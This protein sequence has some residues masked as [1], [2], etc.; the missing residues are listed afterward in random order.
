[1]TTESAVG[2]SLGQPYASAPSTRSLYRTAGW[3]AVLGGGSYAVQ[4]VLVFLVPSG[5]DMDSAA[6]YVDNSWSG[7][8]EGAV[9]TGVAVGV[10]LLVLAVGELVRRTGPVSIA[11]HLA[12]L[13]G[14]AGA[15]A[16]LLVAGSL[17]GL[18]G[19]GS[20][21]MDAAPE[22]AGQA[23][24]VHVS[25]TE[26]FGLLSTAAIAL[27]GWLIGVAT[28]GRRV[29]GV[30]GAVV[31]GLTVLVMLVPLLVWSLP[32]GVLVLVPALL[33]LGVL[34]LVRASRTART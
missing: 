19:S 1:M 20:N 25:G 14:L 11:A 21:L 6:Y 10:A 15:A 26:V 7:A 8:V 29:V 5:G 12:H 32:F 31:A 24:A 17:L 30:S 33:V 3:G 22:A 27:S 16:W 9:F 34:L 13:L 4:P 28:V 18:Y 23:L 2:P